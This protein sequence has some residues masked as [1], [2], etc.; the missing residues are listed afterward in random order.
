MRVVMVAM[1]EKNQNDSYCV[2]VIG[3]RYPPVARMDMDDFYE[4]LA[5]INKKGFDIHI[6]NNLCWRRNLWISKTATCRHF[7]VIVVRLRRLSAVSYC[8]CDFGIL[9]LAA[10]AQ[11]N[12]EIACW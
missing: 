12:C 11:G 2:E 8:F 10:R 6:G 1:K 9:Q 3:W 7:F 4:D 5:T